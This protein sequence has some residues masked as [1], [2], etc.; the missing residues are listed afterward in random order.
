[1]ACAWVGSQRHLPLVPRDQ[2]HS[3]PALLPQLP[4]WGPLSPSG[5]AQSLNQDCF[6]Q[7]KGSFMTF[8]S[9]PGWGAQ[10]LHLGALHGVMTLVPSATLP[11][12][13]L[14]AQPL[15]YTGIAETWH[16]QPWRVS[17]EQQLRR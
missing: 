16:N 1:M 4:G 7:S 17:A 10:V 14:M 3:L 9:A 15:S 5:A 11:P 12:R 6:S 8:S 13:G 2:G